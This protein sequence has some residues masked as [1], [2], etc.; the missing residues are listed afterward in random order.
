MA[1]AL[2]QLT[3]LILA[4]LA[5]VVGAYLLVIGRRPWRGIEPVAVAPRIRLLGVSYIIV[6]GSAMV[7]VIT[8]SHGTRG[9]VLGGLMVLGG[10]I[11][12]V[13]VFLEAKAAKRPPG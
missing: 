5:L 8:N 3:T 6:F 7:Q 9:A 1:T 13:V 2:L 10:A 4:A 12:I 11:V